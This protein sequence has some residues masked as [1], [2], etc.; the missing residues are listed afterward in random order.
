MKNFLLEWI[1][2]VWDWRPW[3]STGGS[4]HVMDG[5]RPSQYDAN[6]TMNGT[7]KAVEIA[8][9]VTRIQFANLG[10]TTEAIRVAFGTTSDHARSNLNM[11]DDGAPE[12]ATTGYYIPAAAEGESV[13]LLGVP[14]EAT[15]FAVANATDGAVASGTCIV[16]ITQG[17]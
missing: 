11:T 13:R 15:Y 2:G 16:A 14:A 4:A 5:F 6:L 9:G 1:D 10:A 8:S 3:K 7:A 17:I 12:H